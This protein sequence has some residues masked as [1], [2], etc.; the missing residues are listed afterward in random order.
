MIRIQ[1]TYAKILE[2]YPDPNLMYSTT[3]RAALYRY[4][5]L[6]ILHHTVRFL[7]TLISFIID[8]SISSQNI[9]K[10]GNDNHLITESAKNT[11]KHITIKSFWIRNLLALSF[12]NLISLVVDFIQQN[13]PKI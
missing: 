7:F 2:P 5:L 1:M 3:L 4:C 8:P 10:A 12:L 9:N 13:V 6:L 11:K